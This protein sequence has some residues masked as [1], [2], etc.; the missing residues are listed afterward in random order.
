MEKFLALIFIFGASITGFSQNSKALKLYNEA[1][2]ILQ[3]GEETM[4]ISKLEQ[5]LDIDSNFIKARYNLGLLYREMQRLDLADKHFSAIIRQQAT[6]PKAYVLRGKIRLESLRLEDALAD[7]QI[8]IQM[9]PY[10]YD[11]WHGLGSVHFM[12]ENYE[13]A[14]EFFTKALHIFPEFPACLNDRASARMMLGKWNAGYEDYKSAV[15]FMP[16]NARYRNNLGIFLFRINK[17]QEAMEQ[18]IKAHQ[19]GDD[20]EVSSNMLLL[21][22]IALEKELPDSLTINSPMFELNAANEHV[23]SNKTELGL[24]L[25]AH[26][27]S[28]FDPNFLDLNCLQRIRMLIS[29]DRFEE[30]CIEIPKCNTAL[31]YKKLVCR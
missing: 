15:L 8:A 22:H 5:A 2:N 25:N 4:A 21:C 30:A 20:L 26:S 23:F 31:E 16:E 10:D 11:G 1:I 13:G 7:F 29:M 6:F 3:E 12:Y 24:E 17:I 18:F 14:E 9:F 19:I 28:E 27:K